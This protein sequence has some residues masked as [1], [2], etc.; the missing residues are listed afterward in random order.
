MLRSLIILLFMAFPALANETVVL[1]LSQR[2][3]AI[4]T[5]F[6]G[7]KILVFGA[8][9]RE[10]EIPAEPLHVIVA[11]SGPSE[12]IV[13]RRKER[14]FGIWLN[15]HSIE[16]DSAPSFYAVATSGNWS[17]TI[18]DTE[19]LRYK[20]SVNRA[21][22]SVGAPQEISDA[23]NFTDALIRIKTANQSYQLLENAVTVDQET[24]FSTAI[25]LPSQLNEGLYTARIYLTRQGKVI[26]NYEAQ[27]DV[28]KVGMERWLYNLSR[29]NAFAYALLSLVI[30]IAAG[31][32]A[33]EAF[34]WLRER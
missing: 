22:R 19:D 20:I 13:V 7:S 31:W 9:K 6:D 2:R 10:T 17:E 26:S 29:E 25:T 32:A 4:S 3:V 14:H 8:V 33:S 34:R 28:H 24:L 1:G 23:G 15:A 5:D 11:I 16:V 30:A 12:P 21:I 18:T 27:I